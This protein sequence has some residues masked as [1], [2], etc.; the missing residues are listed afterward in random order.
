MSQ[1]LS[2]ARSVEDGAGDEARLEG[3]NQG[4]SDVEPGLVSHEG[5]PA[6]DGAPAQ[7]GAIKR[8]GSK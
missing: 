4:A 1:Q 5:L 7:P 8:K 2:D 3:A 6:R